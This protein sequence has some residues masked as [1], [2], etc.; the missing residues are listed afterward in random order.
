[1]PFPMTHLVIANKIVELKPE[2]IKNL[3]QFYLGNLS[4]DAIHFRQK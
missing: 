4:P 3:P 2:A 1:M